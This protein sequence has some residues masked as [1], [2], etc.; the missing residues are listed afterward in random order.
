MAL[1]T[2]NLSLNAIHIEIGGSTGT[3]VSLNDTDIR[4][5]SQPDA[6]Y[7]GG[8]GINT[9]GQ[10]LISMGEF[11]NGYHLLTPTGT[12]IT[13]NTSQLAFDQWSFYVFNYNQNGNQ[14][15]AIAQVGANLIAKETSTHLESCSR[16]R[17]QYR[18]S[19]LKGCA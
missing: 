13:A 10:T 14:G 7:A 16:H 4:G 3:T 19:E 2:V 12:W 11:R 15:E 5:L 1:P 8:D 6:T 18:L 9:S 17:D